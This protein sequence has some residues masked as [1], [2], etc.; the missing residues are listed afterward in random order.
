[1]YLDR[2]KG[3]GCDYT[4]I[5][6]QAAK[7]TKLVAT[8]LFPFIIGDYSTTLVVPI[9][10]VHHQLGAIQNVDAWRIVGLPKIR[11]AYITVI[12]GH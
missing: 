9:L 1:M 12:P 4:T 11:S 10:P 2:T 5:I 6:Q 8:L 3:Y 7:T